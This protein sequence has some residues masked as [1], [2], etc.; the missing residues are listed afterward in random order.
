MLEESVKNFH[1]FF[2]LCAAASRMVCFRKTQKNLSWESME[3]IPA[4][5]FYTNE[6][7]YQKKREIY[8]VQS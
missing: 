4:N 2:R 5:N 6:M 1:F 3:Q 7:M 8:L